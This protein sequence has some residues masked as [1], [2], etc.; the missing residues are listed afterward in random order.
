MQI[1]YIYVYVFLKLCHCKRNVNKW[2]S[3][4]F[5]HAIDHH[6]KISSRGWLVYENQAVCS[7]IYTQH[8]KTW[9]RLK[10]PVDADLRSVLRFPLLMVMVRIGG[11]KL[12]LDLCVRETSPQ[13]GELKRSLSLSLEWGLTQSCKTRQRPFRQTHIACELKLW[14]WPAVR[15]RTFELKT[16]T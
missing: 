4:L 7:I 2:N 5:H 9:S 15:K 11:G 1:L 10:L 16:Q 8:W 12:I 13:V 3:L 14:V 6:P